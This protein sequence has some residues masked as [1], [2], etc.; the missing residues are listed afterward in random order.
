MCGACGRT[1]VADPVL[2][3]VRTMRQHLIVAQTVNDLCRS[4]PGVPKVA[5]T[6]SGWLVVS[7][8]GAFEAVSTVEA[9][10]TAVLRGQKGSPL[11]AA[12]GPA[13]AGADSVASRVHAVGRRLFRESQGSAT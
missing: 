4:W 11:G 13:D 8:T 12:A 2:G 7:P 9:L 3:P 5:A 10:W 6:G 1:V